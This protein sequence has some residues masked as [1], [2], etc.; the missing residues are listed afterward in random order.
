[1]DEDGDTKRSISARHPPQ[2][3]EHGHPR[4]LEALML[5]EGLALTAAALWSLSVVLFK[6][7][8]A[9]DPHGLNL[10]KN[11]VAIVLLSLTML[12]LGESFPTDRSTGDWLR[13]VVSGAVGLGLADTIFFMALRRLGPGL[14]AVVE[15]AYAPTVVLLAVLFLGEQPSAAL[16][17]GALLVVGGVAV[18][19]TE[20]IERPPDLRRGLLLGV[21]AIGCMACGVTLAKPALASGHLV[22]LTLTRLLAGVAMQLTWIAFDPRLH[23]ALAVFRPQPVWRTLLPASFL[24]SYVAMLCWLGGFKWADASV[25]AIL[26]QTATV[27]TIALGVLILREP[28][29]RRRIVG[30]SLAMAG[31]VTIVVLG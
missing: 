6:R 19:S 24:G 8:E 12:A 18:I 9:I 23:S 27:F 10:F 14:L 3:I 16:I 31:A 4:G 5:G 2:P 11:T 7:S 28:L 1:V 26:N 17:P 29:T 21:V 22:E 20:R 25:A 15:C 13:L 30:A